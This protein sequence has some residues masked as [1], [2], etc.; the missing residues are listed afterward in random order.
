MLVYFQ[1]ILQCYMTAL[2][3]S[4]EKSVLQLQGPKKQKKETIIA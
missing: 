4:A 2:H 3:S 1:N